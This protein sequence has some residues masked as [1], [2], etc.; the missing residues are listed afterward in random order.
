M[1]AWRSAS[2]RPSPPRRLALRRPAGNG[3]A[4]G[5]KSKLTIYTITLQGRNLRRVTGGVNSSFQ[6]SWQPVLI[7]PR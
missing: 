1:Q 3:H 5:P 7:A 2:P 6:P 4:A